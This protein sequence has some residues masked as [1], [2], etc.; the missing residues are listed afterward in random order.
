MGAVSLPPNPDY[1]KDAVGVL[2]RIQAASDAMYGACA[3]RPRY[4]YLG[5][6]ERNILTMANGHHVDTLLG[7]PIVPVALSSWLKVGI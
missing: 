6:S 4:V 2:A 5:I 1:T 7:M 3:V